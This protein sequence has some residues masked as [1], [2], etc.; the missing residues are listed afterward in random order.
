MFGSS[1]TLN[2]ELEVAGG[3]VQ[4][5]TYKQPNEPFQSKFHPSSFVSTVYIRFLLS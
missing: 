5:H 2:E 1:T 4:G 3:Q